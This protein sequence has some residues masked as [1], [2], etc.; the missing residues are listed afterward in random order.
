M[1]HWTRHSLDSQCLYSQSKVS[2]LTG[3]GGFSSEQLVLIAVRFIYTVCGVWIRGWKNATDCEIAWFLSGMLGSSCAQSSAL[4]LGPERGP[5]EQGR[6]CVCALLPPCVCC[7]HPKVYNGEVL[8]G[9]VYACPFSRVVIPD[10]LSHCLYSSW[11]FLQQGGT[12]GVA[13]MQG[14]FSRWLR[15]RLGFSCFNWSRPSAVKSCVITILLMH[16]LYNPVSPPS[17]QAWCWNREEEQIQLGSLSRFSYNFQY[18]HNSELQLTSLRYWSLPKTDHTAIWSFSLSWF[19]CNFYSSVSPLA[20]FADLRSTLSSF[21]K[22]HEQKTTLKS[23]MLGDMCSLSS[24]S[25]A[26]C[27]TGLSWLS[28]CCYEGAICKKNSFPEQVA[29]IIAWQALW[30]LLC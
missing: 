16:W 18:M 30:L 17:D 9:C 25:A 3:E 24:R 4:I 6:R 8:N 15:P 26:A 13:G 28:L 27:F 5:S 20:D 10:K 7:V 11:V 22:Q 1:Q 14:G 29:V 19:R 21:I 2:T 12:A 23:E